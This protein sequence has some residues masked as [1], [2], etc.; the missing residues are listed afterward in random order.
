M[1][2]FRSLG[3]IIRELQA[4]LSRAQKKK[5][6]LVLLVIVVGSGF[7][8]LGVTAV[9]PFIQSLLDPEQLRQNAV[10]GELCGIFHVETE[11]GLIYLCGGLLAL[12]YIVK[13]LF[14]LGSYYI[15]ADYSTKTQMDLS[16]RMLA[17]YIRRP[18]LFFS[19]TNSSEILRGIRD[20]TVGVYNIVSLLFTLIAETITMCFIA[21]YI[22]YTDP[23]IAFGV[24]LLSMLVMIFMVTAMK[25][26]MKQAGER[27]RI[28]IADKNKYIYQAVSGIKEIF[29]LR[30][31]NYFTGQYAQASDLGRKTQRTYDFLINCPERIIEGICLSG[32][33]ILVCVR[34][35]FGLDM[36]TF[37]PKLAA[38]AM[39]GFKIL[40]SIGK[41]TNRITGIVFNRPCLS[42]VY[43]ILGGEPDASEC[44]KA[45]GNEDGLQGTLHFEK[46]IHV[47]EVSFQYPESEEAV[48]ESVSFTIHKGESVA[49]I[50]ASGAGKSTLMDMLL[51]LLEPERGR[52]E[53]D[54]KNIHEIPVQWAKI[55]GYVPQSLFLIDDTIRNNV[56][57]GIDR[58]KID[59]ARVWEVLEMAQISEF[60][61]RLPEKLDT[62]VGERG[63][64]FSGGQ[65]QRIAIARALYAEPEVIVLDEATSALD[66]DTEKDVMKAIDLLRG[67]KTLIIVAHRLSTIQNC[68]TVYEVGEKKIRKQERIGK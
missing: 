12:L 41:I 4:V 63:I 24:L 65:C 58:E 13:N 64:R 20:D 25:P 1:K 68:D 8:L 30:R 46:E 7:E 15:Q 50:G 62:I 32:I 49:F 44:G 14:I 5:A 31:Q 18:Y 54:G 33:I 37:V 27:N 23:F 36:T 55:V 3:K 11:K 21:V 16:N 56:A 61:Q 2:N 47:T 34:I 28:A 66:T 53:M 45:M 51:G 38:F 39:A 60:V 17:A 67:K 59:D 40:P 43:E 52:I 26:K 19:K 6:L 57:F 35:S 10:F 48:L 42:N 29:V 9:L 22:I